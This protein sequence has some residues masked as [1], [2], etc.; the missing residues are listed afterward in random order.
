MGIYG[1]KFDNIAES[2][3]KEVEDNKTII[4]IE[5]F[6]NSDL[7]EQV[8]MNES[9]L[10]ENVKVGADLN[11]LGTEIHIQIRDQKTMVR[12]NKGD[13]KGHHACSIKVTKPFSADILIPSFEKT[14][15]APYK[16][17]KVP[18]KI[19]GKVEI[20][21]NVKLDSATKKSKEMKLAL[22]FA[23]EYKKE[24]NLIWYKTYAEYNQYKLLEKI[25]KKCDYVT[26]VSCNTQEKTEELNNVIK[27]REE[28]KNGNL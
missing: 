10:L 22:Q 16:G 12:N 15:E 18:G 5:I 23:E 6:V 21:D 11:K 9:V 17:A 24:L 7:Y 25:I 28:K 2:E 27:K 26:H 20:D 3:R 13:S 8:L 1:H 19:I 14:G 4:T